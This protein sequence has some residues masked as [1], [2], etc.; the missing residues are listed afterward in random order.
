MVIWF[1]IFIN[2]EYS[3]L[4]RELVYIV[5]IMYKLNHPAQNDL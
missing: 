5:Y 4:A 1:A 3:I 2:K